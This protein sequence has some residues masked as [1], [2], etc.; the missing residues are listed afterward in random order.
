MARL[1][2][3]RYLNMKLMHLLE[4][5]DFSKSKDNWNIASS[6]SQ[7]RSIIFTHTKI[8][9]FQKVLAKTQYFPTLQEDEYLYPQH[10]PHIKVKRSLAATAKE[11]T[12]VLEKIKASLFGQV[13]VRLEREGEYNWLRL[14]QSSVGILDAGQKRAFRVTFDGEGVDDNGGPYREVFMDIC[15]ELQSNVLPLFIPSPNHEHDVG[16][17]REKFVINPTRTSRL[18]LDLYRFL[19]QL[20]GM[21]IRSDI[22]LPLDWPSLIWKPLVGLKTS[23]EDLDVIDFRL[24]KYLND[25]VNPPAEH[26]IN[27]ETFESVY[28]D[29]KFCTISADGKE[30]IEII[31]NGKRTP[32][33]WN[34]RELFV[35]KMIDYKLRETECQID[36]IKEGLS[37]IIPSDFLQMFTWSEMEQL[38]SGCIDV[39]LKRLK[40]HTVYEEVSYYEDHVQYFWKVLESLTPY[41]RSQFLRFVWARSRLPA[42]AFSMPFKIQGPPPLSIDKPDEHLPTAQTC[43][44]S[45]SLP[46][47]S[48]YEI[49]REKLLYTIENCIDMD[50]DYRV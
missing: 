34:N 30:T 23:R 10:L 44:F 31:P 25:I 3:L 36:A 11:K 7:I 49:T 2:I 20:L 35:K 18:D 32:V 9:V 47:Y 14:R 39:D 43:F 1:S 45:L 46:R 27:A 6:I 17:N 8:K 50:N 29:L 26:N 41:Q 48:S 5:V 21:A 28:P 4:L 16:E 12:D 15:A 42:T 37:E 13:F 22:S 19:G 38:V 24:S 33:T 40:D